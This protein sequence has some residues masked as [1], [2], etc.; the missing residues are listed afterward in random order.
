[1]LYMAA[2]LEE[3]AWVGLPVPQVTSPLAMHL[4]LESKTTQSASVT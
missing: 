2:T 4:L 3:V 1:M